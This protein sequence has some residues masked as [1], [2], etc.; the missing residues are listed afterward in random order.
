M[1]APPVLSII[2]K[3]ALFHWN[4]HLIQGLY[5]QWNFMGS[6]DL[7]VDIIYSPTR[8][9]IKQY[10]IN[11]EM[12]LMDRDIELYYSEHEIDIYQTVED[13]FF[14]SGAE[15]ILLLREKFIVGDPVIVSCKNKLLKGISC[16]SDSERFDLSNFYLKNIKFSRKRGY[17][18]AT[19]MYFIRDRYTGN[20]REWY[21]TKHNP[22]VI[23][24]VSIDQNKC[25]A[26]LKMSQKS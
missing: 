15:K 12:H 26:F 21:F 19:G 7:H 23:K 2:G 9:V 22:F 20:E 10:V 17:Y 5:A 4:T 11:G 14:G 18:E 6:G 16:I 1:S 25:Q 13:D 3:G 24:P 8:N